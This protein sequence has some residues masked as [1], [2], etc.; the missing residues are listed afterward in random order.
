MKPGNWIIGMALISTGAGIGSG[1]VWWWLQ[2]ASA[3]SGIA[4][5]APAPAKAPKEGRR[6]LYWAAPMN[7]SIHSDHPMRDSMGMPYIPVYAPGQTG[8]QSSAG[9][10]VN[11]RLVQNLGVRVVTVERRQM[12][13]AIHTVGIVAVDEN[14]IYAVN[15]HFSGWA[16]RLHVRAVGDPV[17][18]GQVVAEIY[19]PELFSA[20]QE[21][22]I[23]RQQIGTA[24]GTALIMAA[25]AKLQ[26]L[27]MS[28]TD[29]AA[30]ARRGT[31]HRNVVV[32]A[33]ASG[34]IDTLSVRQG[35]YITPQTSLMQIA[36]LSRV[37]VDVA[38]Y[39]Y[40][41]PWVRI[42]NLVHIRLPAYPGRDWEG[43][44]DFL[45]PT[46]DPK[47]RTVTARLSF[48]NPDGVL[49]PGMYSDATILASPHEAL[50]VPM[51]A[52]LRTNQGDFVMLAQG[53]GHFLPVQV[54]L[55]PEADGWVEIRHGL[56]AGER[57][58]ESAQFLLYSESRFQSVKARMLGGN[59]APIGAPTSSVSN[60]Q[61]GTIHD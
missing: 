49:R 45:Y 53:Q 35:G 22:L 57:V 50:A 48:P 34:V 51:S 31:A 17:K 52:I 54:A 15:P 11:P 42:G 23:A 38:L 56:K 19:S 60:G 16:E 41:L 7:P 40:Q 21:Y 61:G 10:R 27:G 4:P 47:S 24:D 28:D 1:A 12:G 58:V 8:K 9:L 26:L 14:R 5:M 13:H 44:L 37:W 25:K 33:P 30:L 46:L 36:N 32:A 39:T 6:I 59:L 18:R 20:Q 55:G 29:I 2:P 43:H 3:P